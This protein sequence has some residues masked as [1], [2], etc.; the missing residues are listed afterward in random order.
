MAE[1]GVGGK[2]MEE[3]EQLQPADTANGRASA[4]GDNVGA[5]GDIN[6]QKVVPPLKR[7]SRRV[8]LLS[9]V[10]QERLARGE[11]SAPEEAVHISD[12]R[13][14]HPK[15][16]SPQELAARAAK[17]AQQQSLSA[18]EREILAEVP[19]HFGKI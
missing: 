19:P 13:G 18:H 11:I 9:R 8:V 4:A 1:V 16:Y 5:A 17:A 7:K 15:F 14:V 2:L 3:A 12:A 10:D 6:S